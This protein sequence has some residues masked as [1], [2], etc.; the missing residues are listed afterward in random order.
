MTGD[1]NFSL[2]DESP[3]YVSL[4][5]DSAPF[6]IFSFS[7]IRPAT[8]SVQVFQDP[9]LTALQCR[10]IRTA[11]VFPC[12]QRE[13]FDVWMQRQTPVTETPI[14]D[15]LRIIAGW[16]GINFIN[17][18]NI[19]SVWSF[20]REVQLQGEYSDML[21]RLLF[22]LLVPIDQWDPFMVLMRLCGGSYS[23]SRMRLQ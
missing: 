19:I 1:A 4:L 6:C 16:P 14:S 22:S 5:S 8:S 17:F 21:N 10:F 15:K 3:L 23:K 2:R 13:N 18:C 7:T 20:L 11:C 12:R 9:T